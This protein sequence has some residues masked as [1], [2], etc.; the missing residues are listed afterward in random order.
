[1][2][3]KEIRNKYLKPYEYERIIKVYELC[4]FDKEHIIKQI[5]RI[6]SRFE[7]KQLLS[8]CDRLVELA[9]SKVMTDYQDE[10]E[11]FITVYDKLCE[12]E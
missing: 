12:F 11:Y 6:S 4:S 10:L 2:N 8:N 5:N 9:L 3:N 1:M 7:A